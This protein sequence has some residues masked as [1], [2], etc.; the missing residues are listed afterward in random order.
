[1]RPIDADAL[2]ALLFE[3]MGKY[4]T[5]AN[6]LPKSSYEGC[7]YYGKVTALYE[8]QL[9]IDR[10]IPT[11]DYATVV[12]GEWKYFKTSEKTVHITDWLQCSVCGRMWDRPEGTKYNYCPSCGATM[13]GGWKHDE[14]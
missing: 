12:H 7:V 2:S 8:A 14:A 11:L 13:D 9:A 4:E 6:D 5:L 3:R 10:I 1:M